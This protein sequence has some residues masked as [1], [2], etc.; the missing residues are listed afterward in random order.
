[1]IGGASM[2][3]WSPKDS[4]DPAMSNRREDSHA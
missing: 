4:P 2:D 1:M 3:F